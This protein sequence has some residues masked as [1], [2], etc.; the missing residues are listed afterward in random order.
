VR[1][2]GKRVEI[3]AT[4][5]S[6]GATPIDLASDAVHAALAAI[7][8]PGLRRPI[9]DLGMVGA[10]VTHSDQAL[11]SLTMPEIGYPHLSQLRAD[12]IAALQALD[13]SDVRVDA[14]LM[15]PDD[16]ARLRDQLA[17][18]GAGADTLASSR[19]LAVGS[20]KGGVG[21]STMAANL[22]VALA[23]LGRRVGLLDADVWGFS[24]PRL[25]GVDR[26]PLVLDSLLVPVRAHGVD[27]VSVGLLTEETTPVVWRG[28]M[29]H[30][31][32]EQLVGNV[33]WDSP[34]ILIVDMPPG[35]G[36]VSIS[37]A[38]LLPDAELVVVTTP[39]A[40]AH[41]VAQRAAAMAGR[42]GL[43]VAGVI[44][45]MSWFTAADGVR[46]ELYGTG[47]GELLAAELGIP[48]LGQVP[49]DLALREGADGGVPVAVAAPESDA[50]RSIAS[51]A[52]TLAAQPRSRIRRPELR[53]MDE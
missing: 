13:V 21:K 15:S 16:R 23:S 40:T 32:L 7:V 1:H 19:I 47:G 46:H 53:V 31:M 43:R 9:T 14:T 6:I 18:A 25:L 37:L 52:G 2:F 45:N 5:P 39:Q 28:P 44:E 34:D 26:A 11:V 10:V 8:D 30:K 41:R 12:V 3:G 42:V 33:Y 38:G 49:F 22:A 20:G 36:D 27:V 29:L 48:M 50:A 4:V 17:A 51:I 24:V 35:T